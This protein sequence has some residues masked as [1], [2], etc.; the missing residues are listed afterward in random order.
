MYG[1]YSVILPQ[2]LQVT[3][4]QSTHHVCANNSILSELPR[5]PA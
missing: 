5:I 1:K 2:P 3:L 4:H